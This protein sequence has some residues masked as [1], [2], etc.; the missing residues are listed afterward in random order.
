[1]TSRFPDIP[2]EAMSDEQRRVAAIVASGG[3]KGVV[4]PYPM[5][6][7]SPQLC[8][9][10]ARLGVFLRFNSAMTPALTELA[11]LV[12][13]RHWRAAFPWTAHAALARKAGL[14]DAVIEAT[15]T[16]ATP[17][18][19][20]EDER[21]VHAFCT[22]LLET[23]RVPDALFAQARARF[24]EQGV[25]DLVGLMGYYGLVSLGVN[26]AQVPAAQGAEDP[27][28]VPA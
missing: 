17:P 7:R 2:E 23:R 12:T 4:G 25:V 14:A 27:F 20:S 8:E 9:P 24:G 15:R 11:I 26:V 13:A 3:R 10:T 28:P 5:F 18:G 21:L 1:M 22:T 19:L 6:L 16:G